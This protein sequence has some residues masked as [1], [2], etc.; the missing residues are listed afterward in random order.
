MATLDAMTGVRYKRGRLGLW[1]G[2]EGQVYE[3]DPAVHMINRDE[4]PHFV[5]NYRVIDFG[6]TNPFVCQWWGEDSD[7]RLYMFRE[8]YMSQRTVREHAEV[9]NQYYEPIAATVVDHDAEDR[10]TLHENGIQTTPADK[11][12]SVGIEKVGE[13]LKKVGDGRPRIFFVRD[14][15][16]EVDQNMKDTNRPTS[17]EAEFP[18]YVWPE[19]KAQRAADEK[20]V[21]ADDHGM[22][23]TRYMVMHTDG[24]AILSHGT[25][26]YFDYGDDDDG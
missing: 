1:V 23:A 16:I 11:R 3:F 13:R 22:D 4:C 24:R 5:R 26:S 14:A 19:T 20:P 25:G 8:L 12:M 6:Y 9:I 10:A 18:G 2:R 17:T 21:K 7:G 15:L